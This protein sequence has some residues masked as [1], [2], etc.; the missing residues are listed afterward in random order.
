MIYTIISCM[1]SFNVVHDQIIVEM[2]QFK[3]FFALPIVFYRL[4]LKIF[5]N[6]NLCVSLIVQMLLSIKI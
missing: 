1:Q 2:T 6:P 3:H 4:Y 5:L